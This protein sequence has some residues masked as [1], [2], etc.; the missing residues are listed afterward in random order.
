L[1]FTPPILKE[2]Y[3]YLDQTCFNKHTTSKE[4]MNFFC[5]ARADFI[6]ILRLQRKLSPSELGKHFRKTA[7][8][9]S[10][11]ESGL[12]PLS[13]KEFFEI[14]DYLEGNAHVSVFLEKIESI[15]K[16]DQDQKCL[17]VTKT[18]HRFGVFLADDENQAYQKKSY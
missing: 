11:I 1:I 15:L 7:G 14:V 18:L 2:F 12:K 16:S 13:D 8:Q 3:S 9:I 10:K 6:F 4:R 5:K 17:A